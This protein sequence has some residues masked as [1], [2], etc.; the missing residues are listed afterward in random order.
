MPAMKVLVLL[1]KH[2]FDFDGYGDRLV[3]LVLVYP[4]I[5]SYLPV[6]N[7]ATFIGSPLAGFVEVVKSFCP[8][9]GNTTLLEVDVD[10]LKCRWHDAATANILIGSFHSPLLIFVKPGCF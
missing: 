6:G 7:R 9:F 10:M 3:L 5:C 8:F 4:I 1:F 2:Q